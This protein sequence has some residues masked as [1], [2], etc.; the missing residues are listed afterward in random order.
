[1]KFDSCIVLFYYGT[2][3][4]R[5]GGFTIR[6]LTEL[7]DRFDGGYGCFYLKMRCP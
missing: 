2:I 6:N 1:M 3:N 7:R 4:P 5:I